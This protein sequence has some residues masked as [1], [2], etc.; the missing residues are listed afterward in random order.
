ML[1]HS[2]QQETKEERIKRVSEKIQKILKEED[3]IFDIQMIPQLKIVY[4][5]NDTTIKQAGIS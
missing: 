3:L 1:F 4:V 2:H 5:G